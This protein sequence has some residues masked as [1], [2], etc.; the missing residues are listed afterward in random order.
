MKKAILNFIYK[1]V[2]SESIWKFLTHRVYP[3]SDI[4]IH[5]R[6]EFE[7]EKQVQSNPEL[8]KIFSEKI[9]R[10]GPF[11]GLKYPSGE[12]FGSSL[13]PK[14]LGSYESEISPVIEEV[15]K[16]EYAHVLDVGC[17]EGYYAI[18]LA[19]RMPKS[20][21][22]A[23]DIK[24]QARELTRKMAEKNDVS[25]RV[26]THSF[27]SAETL[28]NFDFQGRGLIVCDCEGY[29]KQL[30]TETA[31]KNLTNCDLIIET[32]DA[33]DLTISYYLEEL[34]SKTHTLTVIKSVDDLQ[35]VKLYHFP[36]IAH[37]DLYSR[38]LI[39]EEERGAVQE[40]H[41]YKANA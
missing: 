9:V 41:F 39:L 13:Y 22:H 24:E 25:D 1:S 17:A 8:K 31:V 40:W 28:T 32:H 5:K 36:E 12:S 27:C 35:K 7:L 6:Q 29:E 3:L 2:E 38:K 16:N 30:F 20:T 33:L 10:N 14:F 11:K 21:I 26:Q 15:C 23:Y 18:G 37:L 19:L 34:F 4:L